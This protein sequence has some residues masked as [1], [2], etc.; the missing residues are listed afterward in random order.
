MNTKKLLAVVVL[1]LVVAAG[2]WA[3]LSRADAD[4]S[5]ARLSGESAARYPLMAPQ[6]SVQPGHLA[7]V[8]GRVIVE[9]ECEPNVS[10]L[11][12]GSM[13]PVGGEGH[14]LLW[15]P[16]AP[17]RV[18]AGDYIVIDWDAGGLALGRYWHQVVQVGNDERGWWAQTRGVAN[19]APDPFLVRRES[20]AGVA[21]G[22]LWR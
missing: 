13:L 15:C 22:V 18:R 21:V 16:A 7:I 8:G 1:V 3:G 6:S 9:P 12:G 4:P 19:M 11:A 20:L 14:W 10:R 2:I 17:E 5:P